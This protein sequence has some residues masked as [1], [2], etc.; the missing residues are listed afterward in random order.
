MADL[1]VQPKK[2]SN[3]WPWILLGAGLL[4]LIFLL[5]RGCDA[6]DDEVDNDATTTTTTTD[7][8]NTGVATTTTTTTTWDNVDFNAPATSYEEITNKDIEVRGNE[9][10]AIYSLG[11]SILFDEGKATLRAD[12]TQN[13]KQI[14][15]S[16]SKR[17]GSGEV[18][19]Y[20]HTDATGSAEANKELA[21]QRTEAVRNWMVQNGNVGDNRISLHPIGEGEPAASNATEGGRQQ[22]RRVDIVARRS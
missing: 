13:L 17:Y 7:T 22:N 12:A 15:E 20:G 4:L 9:N 2:K 18:R 3:I 8:S 6:D 10:Y 14:S 5:S 19:V 1:D 16:I 21:Q 11:E